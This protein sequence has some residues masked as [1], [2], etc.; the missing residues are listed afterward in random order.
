MSFD[1][2]TTIAQK[3]TRGGLFLF[4]GNVCSTV[5][6]AVSAI[7]V[8]R[9]HSR[10]QHE[11]SPYRWVGHLRCGEFVFVE[12]GTCEP[13][14]EA[15]SSLRSLQASSDDLQDSEMINNVT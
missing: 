4:I 1:E 7:V 5:I 10:L 11:A 14:L 13:M 8:T 15:R 2:L 9:R 3:A 12:L 6:L